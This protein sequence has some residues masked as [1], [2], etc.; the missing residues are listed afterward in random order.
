M[1]FINI[2][3]YNKLIEALKSL[4]SSKFNRGPKKSS[5]FWFFI[6]WTISMIVIYYNGYFGSDFDISSLFFC[7]IF[8][9][10]TLL[11]YYVTSLRRDI[12]L[13]MFKLLYSIKRHYYIKKSDIW[14]QDKKNLE[15][16]NKLVRSLNKKLRRSKFLMLE[17]DYD[18]L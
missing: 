10:L 4:E 3:L 11:G 15:D 6:L 13:K 17:K 16:L 18:I 7:I 9:P 2:T 12:R 8:N 14:T 5:H 1:L